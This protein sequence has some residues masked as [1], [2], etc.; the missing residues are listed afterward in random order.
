MNP[1]LVAWGGPVYPW[2]ICRALWSCLIKICDGYVPYP[3]YFQFEEHGH[4]H[5]RARASAMTIHGTWKKHK[6]IQHRDF[7]LV[8]HASPNPTW[9]CLI[10]QIGRGHWYHGRGCY[11]FNL[12]A[13]RRRRQREPQPQRK[14]P[15]EL[16][17]H[18]QDLTSW[19]CIS[20]L[21]F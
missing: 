11:S 19:P 9:P 12:N 14:W 17:Y 18:S 5:G 8:P 16:A 21:C 4:G 2:Y 13:Q 3:G 10:S 1:F 6:K 7:R 20:P 15:S